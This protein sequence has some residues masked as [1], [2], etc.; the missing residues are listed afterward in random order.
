MKILKT[1]L[2]TTVFVGI[3][4]FS[5]FTNAQNITQK[6]S[7]VTVNGTSS[8]HDWAMTASSSTFT[9]T[10]SGNSITN[11]K[12][13]IPVKNLTSTKGNMMNN[14]AYKALKSD[15][16]PNISFTAVSIPVGSGNV[17]GK[18]TIAGVTKN[19]SF[20]VT[21]VK[22]G[23]AY[24][25]DGTET[26]KMSDYGVEKPGFMGVKTGDEVTVKVSIVAQ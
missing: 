5:Q 21:V 7:K 16:T 24:T 11:V 23:T 1:I 15:S 4:T 2:S 19:V 22:K 9:G 25:I 3:L 12:F 10:V 14:K 6:S 26:I 18:M 8:L 20:P 13:S 17:S